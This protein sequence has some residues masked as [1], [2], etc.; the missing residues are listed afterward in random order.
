MDSINN[1]GWESNFSIRPPSVLVTE[2]WLKDSICNDFRLQYKMSFSSTICMWQGQTWT[3][4]KETLL[5]LVC[6]IIITSLTCGSHGRL[7]NILGH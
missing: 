7:Y 2:T 6:W 5:S 4:G 1:L 3:T